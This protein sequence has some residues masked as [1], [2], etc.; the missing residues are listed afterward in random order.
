MAYVTTEKNVL[1][2]CS[3]AAGEK[4]QA[5]DA[6]AGKAIRFVKAVSREWHAAFL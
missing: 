2:L 6:R 3:A 5:E 1:T 4:L